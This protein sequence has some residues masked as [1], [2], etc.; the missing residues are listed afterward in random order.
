MMGGCGFVF[1]EVWVQ[2]RSC[3]RCAALMCGNLLCG[4]CFLVNANPV[5]QVAAWEIG[6]GWVAALFA[7]NGEVKQQIVWLAERVFLV[8]GLVECLGEINGV[9][10][11]TV[12]IDFD[13]IFVPIHT[14]GVE[15]VV[16]FCGVAKRG[17]RGFDAVPNGLEAIF[18][19]VCGIGEDHAAVI[20]HDVDL[21]ATRPLTR[22]AKGPDGGPKSV[23]GF[24]FSAD[25]K[26]PVKPLL[27]AGGFH[28]CG[29]VADALAVLF[30][31]LTVGVVC[32][33]GFVDATG[34]DN[35]VAIFAESVLWLVPL[36]FL[37]ADKAMFVGPVFGIGAAIFVELIMPNQ[38]VAFIAVTGDVLG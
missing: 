34:F 3:A 18:R 15:T 26:A 16:P 30:P 28:A 35:Q 14:P 4:F 12:E 33:V 11:P 20:L 37:V 6:F 32:R 21:A 5:D 2:T 23:L 36:Q 1:D 13:G 38:L 7:A 31:A 24:N 25:F 27:F 29:S 22:G 9:E 17:K 10:Q 8:G 19:C